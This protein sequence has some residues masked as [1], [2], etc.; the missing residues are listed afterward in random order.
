M[1][2]NDDK[3]L[4]LN[5]VECWLHYFPQHEWTASYVTLRDSLQQQYTEAVTVKQE[6]EELSD[7]PAERAIKRPSKEVSASK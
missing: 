3:W 4:L 1:N 2:P 7:K 5:A 6:A